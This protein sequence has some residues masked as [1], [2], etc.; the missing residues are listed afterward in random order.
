MDCVAVCFVDDIW[1]A[2]DSMKLE[3]EDIDEAICA[4]YCGRNVYIVKNGTG[5][6]HAEIQLVKS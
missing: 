6:M 4:D 3:R 2:S 1:V 5:C